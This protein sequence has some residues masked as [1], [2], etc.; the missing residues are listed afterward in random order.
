M[1]TYYSHGQGQTPVH[2]LFQAIAK[3]HMPH[4]MLTRELF[5]QSVRVTLYDT[6]TFL[7]PNK[8][9]ASLTVSMSFL[10]LPT[11]STS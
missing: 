9:K 7:L 4:H 1:T 6:T 8:T 11:I 10:L 2:K 3:S 5:D